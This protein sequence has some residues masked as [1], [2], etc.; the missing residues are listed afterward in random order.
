MSEPPNSERPESGQGAGETDRLLRRL[1]GRREA[2]RIALLFER[3]WPAL[4][5]PLGVAGL[6]VCL[7]LLGVPRL[8]PPW[9]HTLL[10]AVTAVAV[11]ILLLRGLRGLA[12]PDD[13]AA[14][15]RLEIASGLRH[16]PLS[17]LA[18]RPSS[19]NPAADALWTAHVARAVRQVRRLRVGVPRPGLARR[20]RRALRG[21]LVVAL[22]AALVIAGSDGPARLADAMTPNLPIA[23][24]PQAAQLQVWVTPP[25]YTGLAP[26]FLK[27][28]GGP[29][30]VPSGSHLTASLTGGEGAPPSLALNGRAE[31]FRALDAASFQGDLDLTGGGRL[32]VRRGG[33]ELAGWDLSVLAN[34]SPAIAWSEPPGPAPR[35]LQ[36]R[37]PWQVSDD[38]GV[39]QLRAEL[40]LRERPDAPPI[41]LSIPI[42]SG[43]AKSAKGVNLQDLTANPWAGLPVTARLVG[44]DAAGLTGSSPDAGFTLPERIF[45]HPVARALVAVR[46]QLS[47]DP[48]DRASAV[49]ELDKLLLAPQ[50]LGNDTGAFLNLADIYYRLVRG[51]SPQS[52]EQAQQLMWELALHLEEGGAERS[53]RALEA[54]REAVRQALDRA[55][56]NPSEKNRAELDQKL[57][58]LEN[59]IRQHL[60]AL[61]EQAKREGAD[62]SFDPDAQHLDSRDL[63]RMA[64]AA[65]EAAKQGKMDEARNRMAELE[66]MLDQLRNA[67]PERG[68]ANAKNAEKRQR[69]QQQMGALQDMIGRQGGLLDRAQERAGQPT[70][71][72]GEPREPRAGGRDAKPGGQS[73]EENQGAAREADRRVQQALR[74]ALG[75]LMQQFG[76]LTG[77]VPRSLGEADQAMRDAGQALGQGRDD[78]AGQSEQQAIEALQKGGREMS[79][80]MAKQFGPG[81]S[82]EGDDGG[83]PN[84]STGMSLQDGR[85]DR[86][87]TAEGALPGQHG[88]GEKRDPLGRQLGQGTAGSDESDA[89][90]V[91]EEMERQRT[92]A[93]QDELRRRGADR[94]RPQPELDY[95]DRLLKQF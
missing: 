68:R 86:N 10:L 4:W 36:T 27:Q 92:R 91:P 85:G 87:G 45:H 54:A 74:R 7:A 3:I 5:P 6:F 34:R 77:Q 76:D 2:A 40:R 21:G 9:A 80:Q 35:G 70:D 81:Q 39:V 73:R 15:R 17:V 71:R 59:A 82:G 41:E 46:K 37:L 1:R 60:E 65:R 11:V 88:R 16:R 79:Q 12:T 61:L 94:A 49:A 66:R 53:A 63:Q 48:D 56:A 55:T 47:L 29:V 44:H 43:S 72:R 90:R 32:T 25:S 95:I 18:D 38:Y 13:A 58:E 23:P 50:A 24:A 26:L 30:S 57:K 22:V 20:D 28:E 19:S 52:V 62:L 42:P 93:I 31:P 64:E 8:L 69:G 33:R 83:D 78:A 84:G 67:R 14:D 89:V 51:R 75:E